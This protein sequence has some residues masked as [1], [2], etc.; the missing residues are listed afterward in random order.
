[1][2][3]SFPPGGAAEHEDYWK[4]T[5]AFLAAIKQV[6]SETDVTVVVARSIDRLPSGEYVPIGDVFGPLGTDREGGRIRFGYILLPRDLRALPRTIP[7]AG[8]GD[9]QSFA[10]AIVAAHNPALLEHVLRDT[11]SAVP[12]GSYLP[13]SMFI[14]R[15]AGEVLNGD[16]VD[17]AGKIVIVGGAWHER[18]YGMGRLVDL[19]YTP[20][21][22]MP[23]VFVHANFVETL[24]DLR[25]W[26]AAPAWFVH[27]LEF[28]VVVALMIWLASAHR[29]LHRLGR[30]VV[31]LGLIVGVNVVALH[32]VGFYFDAVVPATSIVV[33]SVLDQV[34]EWRTAALKAAGSHS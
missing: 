25:T 33:H 12:Y 6:S 22:E 28:V 34:N 17:L 10:R 24:L 32:F 4:E 9:Q 5:A 21:G 2:S 27:T 29:A 30:I 19:Y 16:L 18:G 15:S 13:S 11:T 7:L 14:Q 26:P 20:A 23:G 1:M 8:G 3:S 31:A